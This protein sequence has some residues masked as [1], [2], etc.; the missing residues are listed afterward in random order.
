MK[1]LLFLIAS[2]YLVSLNIHLI[3][4][5]ATRLPWQDNLPL[6]VLWKAESN[7]QRLSFLGG[8]AYNNLVR[9]ESNRMLQSLKEN[10]HIVMPSERQKKQAEQRLKEIFP[11]SYWLKSN[12]II[13]TFWT[14]CVFTTFD[15]Q[16]MFPKEEFK[17]DYVTHSY[18]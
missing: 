10:G 4:E 5:G 2:A 16:D 17:Y 13:K 8:N 18:L 6:A 14:N 15:R 9:K 1:T 11:Y 7:N 12:Y 3:T